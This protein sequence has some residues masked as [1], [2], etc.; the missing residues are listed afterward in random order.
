MVWCRTGVR[1]GVREFRPKTDLCDRFMVSLLTQTIL[2]MSEQTANE[3]HEIAI[4]YVTWDL[5]P[6]FGDFISQHV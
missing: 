2:N 1:G 3:Q 6:G 4:T 5:S